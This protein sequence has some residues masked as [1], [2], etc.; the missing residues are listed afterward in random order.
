[1]FI[2]SG[3]GVLWWEEAICNSQMGL[4]TLSYEMKTKILERSWCNEGF[5]VPHL[6]H[7]FSPPGDKDSR[8][9]N[10]QTLWGF[11]IIKF[12]Q[13]SGKT[14][15]WPE[16]LPFF[17]FFHISCLSPHQHP[18]QHKSN[19]QAECVVPGSWPYLESCVRNNASLRTCTRGLLAR[20]I[21]ITSKGK[22]SSQFYSFTS[23]YK[24]KF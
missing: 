21:F 12:F 2:E 14:R 22:D 11:S 9:G 19:M 15:A 8:F 3:L 7:S 6:L 20:I 1:M 18:W 4:S 23:L 24:I 5:H 17:L 10:C 13:F 16:I